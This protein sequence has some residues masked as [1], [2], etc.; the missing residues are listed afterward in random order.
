MRLHCVA[1]LQATGF[2]FAMVA[3]H[4]GLDL[5]R[6]QHVELTTRVVDHSLV[7]HLAARLGVERRAVQHDH[8]QLTG[9]EFV[10]RMA[11]GVQGQHFGVGRQ[12]VIAH[13]IVAR[14]RIVERLVHLELARSAGLGFLFFHGSG[15]SSLVHAQA[16]FAAHVGRQVE[17]EAVGVVQ[18]EGH[19]ARQHLDAAF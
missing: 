6:I 13:K 4:I 17:R 15:K 19:F 3:K 16:T 9:L 2:D 11:V 14:A 7:A 10:H 5:E 1:H 18:L 12:V 8:A